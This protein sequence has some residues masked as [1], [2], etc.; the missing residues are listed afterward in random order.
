[1]ALLI[2]LIDLDKHTEWLLILTDPMHEFLHLSAIFFCSFAS[3]VYSLL[4]LL[5]ASERVTISSVQ[6]KSVIYICDPFCEN[7]P[8]RAEAI[9][10]I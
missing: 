5:L 4:L 2:F 8:I 9:I 6:W 3:F 1:M 10:E 7:L